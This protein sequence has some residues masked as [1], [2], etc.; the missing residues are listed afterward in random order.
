M[1]CTHNAVIGVI[2]IFMQSKESHLQD[3]VDAK[4]LALAQADRLI[5]QYRGRKAQIDEEVC[6]RLLAI[7]TY[8]QSSIYPSLIPNQC[9]KLRSLLKDT[10][11]RS[12]KLKDEASSSLIMHFAVVFNSHCVYALIN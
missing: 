11:K 10:E 3:L 6:M 1:V 2:Y 9:L 12:E 7:I 8:V 4:A 5:A